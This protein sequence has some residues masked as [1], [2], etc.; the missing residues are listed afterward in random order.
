MSG[1]Y[2]DARE[3]LLDIRQ[4]IKDSELMTKYKLSHKGL[5]DLY[6]QLSQAGLLKT[7]SHGPSGSGPR[8]ISAAAIANDILA[9]MSDGG[10]T[11]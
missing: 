10:L 9:G 11:D 4:G 7:V 5:E 2:V 8:K 1:R 3:V 6:R